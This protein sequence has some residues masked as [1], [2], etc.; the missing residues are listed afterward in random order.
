MNYYISKGTIYAVS[1]RSNELYHYGVPGMKWGKR[2]ARPVASSNVRRASNAT[3]E[4]QA[5]QR[6]ARKAKL[7]KAAKI[8]AAVAAA[9]LAVY[10][11]HKLDR[12][13]K[14]KAYAKALKRGHK[15]IEQYHS[16]EAW[17]GLMSAK[18]P[19]EYSNRVDENVRKLRSANHTYARNAASSTRN[20][21]RELRSKDPTNQRDLERT[22]RALRNLAAV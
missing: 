1:R 22:T 21:I 13:I 14:S 6:E 16:N 4:Q 8:G 17:N 10:G 18:N 3:P 15:A 11:A 2:K 9:G 20:A 7:K 5:A 12:A 19:W